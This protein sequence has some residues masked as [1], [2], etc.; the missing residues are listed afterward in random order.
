MLNSDVKGATRKIRTIR[1]ALALALLTVITAASI[2]A[3]SLAD[4]ILAMME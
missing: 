1:L 4:E 3:Y 2:F